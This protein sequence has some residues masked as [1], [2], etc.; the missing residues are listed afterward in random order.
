MRLIRSAMLEVLDSEYIKLARAKG[1]SPTMVVWKHALRN[2]LIPPLTF[3]GVT[4]GLLITGSI[5]A[6]TVFQWPGLGLL[7]Y[8]ALIRSDYPTLQGIVMVFSGMYLIINFFVDVL[9]AYID[10]RIRY[11]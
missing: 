7:A 1:V 4:L 10:P 11:S 9:Y 3:M 5:V 6:E 8:T 2:A